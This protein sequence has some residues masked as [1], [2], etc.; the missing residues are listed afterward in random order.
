MKPDF[1]ATLRSPLL[2]LALVGLAV[3]PGILPSYYLHIATLTL[4]YVALGSA[5]NIVGGIGGQISLAHSLFV[6]T[7]AM[8]SSALL[9]KLGLNMWVG[10]VIA[11][12]ISG[13]MGA[14]IA[15]IDFRF[16]LGHLSFA[17][18]TLAFAEMGEIIVIGWEFLGGASGLF[19]PK[20]T[21]NLAAFQFGGGKGA[22]WVMLTLAV[23]GVLV[24]LAI[25]NMPLGYYLRA[26]RDNENAAQAIGVN[27]LR[28]KTIAMVVSAVL[29][30]IIGTAYARYLTF[31]DPYLLA[32]PVLTVE[33]VLIAT[34]GGLGKA[35]GPALGAILL[36]PLGE[37]LRG[38][39]G[40]VLPG[41]HYFIYGAVVITVIMASPRG[42]LPP[43][44]ALIA[45][46][47]GRPTPGS[48]APTGG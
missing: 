22:F 39:L 15:F 47:R 9:I 44:Q 18:I 34:V 37:I 17:L 23:I 12:I 29:T 19:L 4:V 26:I 38:K 7:G 41:L 31:A 21:G 33:I 10:M 1:L 30:S 5:W 35:L 46:L 20:D 14:L 36:I 16:R 42:L 48:A 2:W 28:N 43:V 32:S 25:L 11:A 27:L 13:L 8:L 40:G 6:G 24:N 3:L 45:R